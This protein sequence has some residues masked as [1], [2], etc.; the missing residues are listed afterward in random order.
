MRHPIRGRR[1]K[2]AAVA[3]PL[4]TAALFATRGRRDARDERSAAALGPLAGALRPDKPAGAR[5]TRDEVVEWAARANRAGVLL[6]LSGYNLTE[7]DLK[8]ENLKLTD[9][10]F[11]WHG[12]PKPAELRGARFRECI[13]E[14]CFFADTDLTKAD[15]RKCTALRCDFRYATFRHTTLQEAKLVLCDMYRA[16]IQDGTV[17]LKTKFELVS[18]TG[19]LGG[20]TGLR[21][22]S[23]AH[24][25]PRPPLVPESEREYREFLRWTKQDRLE[26]YSIDDALADRLDDAA[27]NYRDLSGLWT[28]R[29]Q[30]SDAGKAYAR[31]RRLERQSA[32]PRFKGKPFRPLFWAGLWFADLLCGFGE[33]LVKIVVW[34]LVVALL[35]GIVYA[36]IGNVVQGSGGFWDDLLFSASQLTAST[37]MRLSS[38]AQVVEWIRVLQTLTGVAV[39][40]LFG[41]VLGNKIR[42]S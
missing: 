7:I 42:N 25:K 36:I 39:L 27:R 40:G 12:G 24:E 18:L 2:L 5:L 31:S 33:S 32:G 41:F 1:P 15:F 34:L 19:T 26:A 28:E 4:R 8:D 9:V 13:L 11:G 38:S 14:H 22:S 37:P 16:S 3:G 30:F 21:W 17:M 29:G 23:F 10:V 35:P 6:N 20:A